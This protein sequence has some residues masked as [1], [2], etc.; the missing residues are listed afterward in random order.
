M[1]QKRK[2]RRRR[3]RR[4]RKRKVRVSMPMMHVCLCVC[5]CMCVCLSVTTTGTYTCMATNVIGQSSSQANVHVEPPLAAEEPVD[6]TSYVSPETLRRLGLRSANSSSSS[7]SSSV[8]LLTYLWIH[9]TLKNIWMKFPRNVR[10]AS[11]NV[12][13]KFGSEISCGRRVISDFH[14]VLIVEPSCTDQ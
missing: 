1:T 11:R 6:E 2:M 3:R 8:V 7:S 4:R 13:T 12:S 9:V 10:K 5:R 14:L